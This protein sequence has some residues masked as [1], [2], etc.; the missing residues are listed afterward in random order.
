MI[1]R[2]TPDMTIN[3]LRP[4]GSLQSPTFNTMIFKSYLRYMYI[5]LKIT[6]SQE[7]IKL[8]FAIVGLLLFRE[9][10]CTMFY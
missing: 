8:L 1:L 7:D 3:T 4:Y 5:K 2:V 9:P 6:Q 10:K